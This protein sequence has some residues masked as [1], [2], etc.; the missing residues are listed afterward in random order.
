MIR[1]GWLRNWF[2]EISQWFVMLINPATITGGVFILVAEL[3]RRRRQSSRM[4]AL[5]LFTCYLYGPG[6]FYQSVGIWFRGP[7]WEFYWSR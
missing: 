3:V 5:A 6:H 4:A 1:F 2:P 7:N